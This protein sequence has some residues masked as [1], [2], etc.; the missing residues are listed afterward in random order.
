MQR[1][2]S[3][4]G[5]HRY[6]AKI[7]KSTGKTVTKLLSDV[8]YGSSTASSSFSNTNVGPTAALLQQTEELNQDPDAEQTSKYYKAKSIQQAQW[9]K[10]RPA[11]MQV[12]FE[13]SAPVTKTCGLCHCACDNLVCCDDCGPTYFVCDNCAQRDHQLRPF[14]SLSVWT[15]S[16]HCSTSLH[17]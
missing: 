5:G 12:A 16:L 8:L 13:R 11:L 6:V 9:E 14:H 1:R 10:M 17:K 3:K 2:K 15:V 4:L 7:H